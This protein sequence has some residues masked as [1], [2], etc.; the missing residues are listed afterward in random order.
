MTVDGRKDKTS[1]LRVHFVKFLQKRL[2]PVTVG[3]FTAPPVAG[4]YS[5]ITVVTKKL[6]IPFVE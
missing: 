6:I 1:L 5:S 2:T 4:L 3:Y